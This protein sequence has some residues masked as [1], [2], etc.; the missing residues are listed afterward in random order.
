ML[1]LVIFLVFLTAILVTLLILKAKVL[2]EFIRDGYDDHFIISLHILGGLIS[3]KY[4]VPLINIEK[5]GVRITKVKEKRDI[6][7]AEEKADRDVNFF[8]IFEKIKAI[9]KARDENRET[10]CEIRKYLRGK[11]VLK[12]FKF[13][14]EL[15]AGD[16]FYT[17]ILTGVAWIIV[18][19]LSSYV[20]NNVK[21]IDNCIKVESNFNEKK[22]NV[23][24]HCIFSI[25]IV[26]IIVVR[27]KIMKIKARSRQTNEKIGGGLSG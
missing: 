23:N 5:N 11:L 14:A 15:G 18:G 12:N 26:H 2:L 21:N 22:L 3:Y 9:L 13:E 27:L 19:S 7:D 6:K 24:L 17:G 16:A 10:I 20:L 4:E 8:S 1:Y 25:R